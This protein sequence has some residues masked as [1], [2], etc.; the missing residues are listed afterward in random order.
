MRSTATLMLACALLT[1]SFCGGSVEE[2]KDVLLEAIQSMDDV[3][4]TPLSR[5]RTL[6]S[7][8]CS[9]CHGTQ[10]LGDGFNAFNLTPPPRNFTDSSFVVRLDTAAVIETITNGGASVGLSPSM[11][12]WGR[13]LTARDIELLSRYVFYLVGLTTQ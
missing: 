12:P 2:R 10:G 6:Y 13:T 8:Y 11:P 1:L 4:D 7:R 5:G 3:L 9:V